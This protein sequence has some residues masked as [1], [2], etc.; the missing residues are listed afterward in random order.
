MITVEKAAPA[1]YR[2]L[3]PDTVNPVMEKRCRTAEQTGTALYARIDG[4]PAGFMLL[5]TEYDIYTILY[6]YTAPEYRSRGVMQALINAAKSDRCLVN[7]SATDIHE[8]APVISHV[9]EK[10][11]FESRPGRYIYRC[12]DDEMWDRWDAFME[13][14]G[15]SRCETLIRQGY[16]TVKL[17]E[18]SEDLI[19]QF[20]DDYGNE[21]NHMW[22]LAPGAEIT[23]DISVMCVR[24]GK[25]AAYVFAYMPDRITAI[26]KTLSSSK[27]LHGTGAALLPIAKSAELVRAKGVKR[28][29]F[30]FDG[31]GDRANSFR[32]KV[33]SPLITQKSR[34]ITYTFDP[35]NKQ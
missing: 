20:Y 14:T 6:T 17:T 26:Y 13:K 18:A 23:R 16:S 29:S 19:R 28:L 24:D 25:L 21:L 5:N 8:F 33:L 30:S 11:G 9:M 10:C 15:N 7:G 22:M 35:E 3:F 1:L 27:A 34:R 4:T 31:V 2:G 12:C 32:D